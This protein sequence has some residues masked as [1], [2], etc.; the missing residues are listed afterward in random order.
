MR[1][2]FSFMNKLI[3]KLSS[4]RYLHI[5]FFLIIKQYRCM[6]TF[7]KIQFSIK[8]TAA[9]GIKCYS[10]KTVK[11]KHSN[12]LFYIINFFNYFLNKFQNCFLKLLR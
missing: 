5:I 2:G 9:V 12:N 4:Y 6:I 3:R 10:L 8:S 11:K 1:E 7:L